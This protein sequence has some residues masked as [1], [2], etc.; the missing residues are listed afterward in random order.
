MKKNGHKGA[1]IGV[2][3]FYDGCERSRRDY[4]KETDGLLRY[5]LADMGAFGQRNYERR[6]YDNQAEGGISGNTK[7]VESGE[8]METVRRQEDIDGNLL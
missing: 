8:R 3:T 2:Q 7:T 6:D 1:G 4:G 5:G